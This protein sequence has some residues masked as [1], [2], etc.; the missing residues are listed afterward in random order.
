[1]ILQQQTADVNAIVTADADAT[2]VWDFL[3]ETETAAALSGSLS[4]LLSAA[5]VT[6]ADATVSAEITAAGSSFCF[7]SAADAATTAFAN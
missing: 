3:A 2:T 6:D 1:M 4:C 7:C 5:T